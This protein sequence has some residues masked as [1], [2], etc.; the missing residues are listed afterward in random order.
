MSWQNV[1]PSVVYRSVI[2]ASSLIMLY[3]TQLVCL[4]PPLII[5]NRERTLVNNYKSFYYCRMNRSWCIFHEGWTRLNGKTIQNWPC[6][7]TGR[8]FSF[9][10]RPLSPFPTFRVETMILVT[11][12]AIVGAFSYISNICSTLVKKKFHTSHSDFRAS[13][14]MFTFWEQ[15]TF[16]T[17]AGVIP[18]NKTK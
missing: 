1:F 18:F 6:S 8:L 11:C 7:K 5:V 3:A 16:R 13:F 9:G 15:T 2:F 10:S 17:I 4:V 12:T 14:P